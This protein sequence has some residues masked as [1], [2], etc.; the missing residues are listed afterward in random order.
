MPQYTFKSLLKL[1][2]DGSTHDVPSPGSDEYVVASVPASASVT[3]QLVDSGDTQTISLPQGKPGSNNIAVLTRTH[4]TQ[5]LG[6]T[7][8]VPIVVSKGS[9]TAKVTFRTSATLASL[10][11][12]PPANTSTKPSSPSKALLSVRV[13]YTDSGNP[14]GPYGYD[15]GLL[16]LKL[17]NGSYVRARNIA[18]SGKIANVFEVPASFTTGTVQI[19]GT[20]AASG[21]VKVR[22]RTLQQIPISIPA[23]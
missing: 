19:T 8:N 10:D 2:V 11:Y 14:G 5:F 23:G 18:P 13:N 6:R 20:V 4:R 12:W 22:V 9:R 21:G 17:P 16:R 7:L 15:P 3:L 1:A